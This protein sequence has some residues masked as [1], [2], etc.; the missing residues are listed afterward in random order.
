MSKFNL[1]DFHKAFIEDCTI[2]YN[3][4]VESYHIALSDK[5]T[6][7]NVLSIYKSEL[8]EIGIWE[9]ITTAAN[10]IEPI[11]VT[12]T[13]ESLIKLESLIISD[14]PKIN[15]TVEELINN[16]ITISGDRLNNILNTIKL[17]SFAMKLPARLYSIIFKE[18]NIEGFNNM[19]NGESFRPAK[20]LSSFK[21][22]LIDQKPNMVNKAATAKTYNNLIKQG[23]DVSDPASYRVNHTRELFPYIYWRKFNIKLPNFQFYKFIPS[24]HIYGYK[25]A[26]DFYANISNPTEVFNLRNKV[27][28]YYKL[29]ALLK[30]STYHHTLFRNGV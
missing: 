9:H 27:G 19:M 8:N 16:F 20:G 15:R 4:A 6:L 2:K 10:T 25:N 17:Y 24:M 21:I 28:N 3:K 12:F 18:Y 29:M 5:L 7:F 1:S 11:Y 26:D 13:F 30:V 22:K 14:N 23:K